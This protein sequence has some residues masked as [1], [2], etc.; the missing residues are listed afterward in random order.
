MQKMIT[1]LF[2]IICFCLIARVC[3]INFFKA[4]PKIN[5][6]NK[7][8]F[9]PKNTATLKKYICSFLIFTIKSKKFTK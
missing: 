7:F 6:Q 3:K 4:S 1:Q 2:E 9:Y 5:Q 8:Y